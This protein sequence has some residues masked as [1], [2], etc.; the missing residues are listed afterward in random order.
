[1]REFLISFFFAA[2]VILPAFLILRKKKPQAPPD[3]TQEYGS[4]MI[5]DR[6][7]K[8]LYQG[9]KQV[10]LEEQ[11]SREDW[12]TFRFLHVLPTGTS[13]VGPEVKE[14]IMKEFKIDEAEASGRLR[15][16]L[17]AVE[18]VKHRTKTAK[19]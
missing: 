10:L 16:V 12:S 4:D 17:R 15:R 18:T 19:N 2:A 7:R 5:V 3:P 9:V 8:Q 13:S 1:M 11:C 14:L 6:G